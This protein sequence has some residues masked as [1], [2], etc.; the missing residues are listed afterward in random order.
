MARNASAVER[1]LSSFVVVILV[2]ANLRQ[3][4]ALGASVGYDELYA[5]GLSAYYKD[6]WPTAVAKIEEAIEDWHRERNVTVAC[7]TECRDFM[8]AK[9]RK[10][11]GFAV[12]FFHSLNHMRSCTEACVKE[13]LGVRY[14]ISKDIRRLFN[15]R[16]PFSFLQFAYHKVKYL[17]AY[18]SRCSTLDVSTHATQNTIMSR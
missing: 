11:S 9:G 17:Y 12:E 5:D 14:K 15:D 2:V 4:V 10:S 3:G 8:E 13:N 7:R 18:L 16:E 6:D 1:M